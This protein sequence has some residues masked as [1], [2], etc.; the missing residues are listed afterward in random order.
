MSFDKAW[1][2][3]GLQRM[4]SVD[5]FVENVRR[6]R[7]CIEC[8][9][10]TNLYRMSGM[11]SIVLNLVHS[12]FHCFYSLTSNTPTTLTHF[13][14]SYLPFVRG[15]CR[16]PVVLPSRYQVFLLC[17][18]CDPR[19]S[20]CFFSVVLWW[21]CALALFICKSWFCGCILVSFFLSLFYFVPMFSAQ[22][23][24]IYLFYIA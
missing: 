7:I 11:F 21:V 24:F 6:G 8:Q 3:A 16:Q 23:M 20:L 13:S 12:I 5:R 10:W 15:A 19:A 18:L 17:D 14:P 2:V 9:A 4:S 22:S 1:S